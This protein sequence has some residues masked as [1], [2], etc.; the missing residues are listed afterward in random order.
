MIIEITQKTIF[1]SSIVLMLLI[2]IEYVFLTSFGNLNVWLKKRKSLQIILAA[3]LGISPGCAGAFAVVNFYTHNVFYFPALLAAFIATFGDEAYFILST[4]PLTALKLSVFLLILS[5]LFSYIFHFTLMKI[6]KTELPTSN[7]YITHSNAECCLKP[8][9]IKISEIKN[10]SFN[11][12]LLLCVILLIVFISL[13]HDHS[14]DGHRTLSFELIFYL[15][16]SLLTLYIL[17]VVPEHFLTEHLWEHII[18]KHFFKLFIWT[19]IVI[20]LIT[21]IQHFIPEA[22]IK[23]MLEKNYFYLLFTSILVGFFPVSGPNL[24]FFNLYNA[25]LIPFVVLLTNS[26]VQDGHAG[27][28]LLAEKKKVFFVVKIIKSLIALTIGICYKYLAI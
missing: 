2:V 1:I 21:V 15:I 25:G 12:V 23:K 7:H 28:P 8:K 4:S 26:L 18:K 6:K 22:T 14:I 13:F 5:L 20:A 19:L 24:I 27:I 16:L 9:N 3:L 10:F 17:I 11:R